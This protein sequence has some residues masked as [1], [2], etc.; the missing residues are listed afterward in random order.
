MKEIIKIITHLF[1]IIAIITPH[2]SYAQITS[3]ENIT[4][5]G[6]AGGVK[7]SISDDGVYVAFSSSSTNLVLGDTNDLGDI[8]LY[9]TDSET[10]TRISLSA[11]GAQVTDESSREPV[12]SGN[13]EAV[14][15]SSSSDEIVANDM[16]GVED[17][18]VFDT[19]TEN[20][21][22]ISVSS[23]GVEANDSSG[24]AMISYDGRYVVFLSS[25]SNLTAGDINGE[26][27][28]FVYDRDLDSIE[29]LTG[30]SLEGGRLTTGTIT[31]DGRYVAFVAAADDLVGDDSNGFKDAFVYDRNTDT[32]ERVSI[33]SDGTEGDAGVDDNYLPTLSSDGRYVAFTST[34]SNLVD[35]DMNGVAD[36]FVYDRNTDTIERV[37]LATDGTESDG[38]A[39]NVI[40]SSDGRFVFFVSGATNLLDGQINDFKNIFVRDMLINLTTR[41]TAT[42]DGMA[43]DGES[44][45]SVPVA[46][47][48]EG[49]TII[50][51]TNSTNF[52]GGDLNG[53]VDVIIATVSDDDSIT[54]S[55]ENL[56]PNDG[57]AD[58]S[59][60]SDS[61][62]HNVSSFLNSDTGEYITLI[63]EGE[64]FDNNDVAIIDETGLGAEDNLFD[65]PTGI[66]DFNTGCRT[67]SGDEATIT[68]YMFGVD[69]GAMTLRKIN[70]TTG[71][72]ELVSSYTVD[73]VM[74]GGEAALK[75][76]YSVED[77]GTLDEDGA[78]NGVIVDPVG[79]AVA[80]V[81]SSSGNSSS[82]SRAS[83]KVAVINT[84]TTPEKVCYI[85]TTTMKHGSKYGE[86]AKLQ[87][88]LLKAGFTPGPVDGLFGK[89]TLAAAKG[90]QAAHD[91]VS[92][93]I[94]GPLTR[95]MLNSCK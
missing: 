35:D 64:C 83:K 66:I 25:A 17:I 30:A 31:P 65:Y 40:M 48:N 85:F 43:G 67:V 68:V 3:I 61:I 47:A 90:F 22:R 13:G 94:V 44:Y 78:S 37:S 1:V 92:D 23:L 74:I 52:V 38:N 24:D 88:A 56:A 26:E 42:E 75:I 50:F 80:G 46:F 53:S 33:A 15:F 8:F 54:P 14:A 60:V 7:G 29:N 58:E 49:R 21:E 28:V 62:E 77:G 82:G 41:V 84:P 76:E 18:F 9:N 59:N 63:S 4:I 93:G 87:E 27:D 34:A 11:L 5:D 12:I 72:S 45:Q 91:L 89:M 55:I 16:N 95:A 69:L 19:N 79:L 2:M 10:M 32:I 51:E 73:P 36:A 70:S 20:I 81:S 86:V 71:V 39:E 57:D 6:D